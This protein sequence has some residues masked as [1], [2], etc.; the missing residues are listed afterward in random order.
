MDRFHE[1]R[2]RALENSVDRTGKWG[3]RARGR[4]EEQGRDARGQGYNT[5][6][7][8]GEVEGRLERRESMIYR[9]ARERGR[10]T[11][12]ERAARGQ[13][14]RAGREVLEGRTGKMENIVCGSSVEVDLDDMFNEISK[15]MKEKMETM[16]GNANNGE[17]VAMRAG[18]KVMVETVEDMLSRLSERV[19]AVENSVFGISDIVKQARRER[20]NMDD[21]TEVR[22]AKLEENV[23]DLEAEVRMAKLEDK[24]QD[25]EAEMD[26]IKQESSKREGMDEMTDVRLAKFEDKV[27]TLE[28]KV[29][30][31][32]ELKGE[33]KVTEEVKAMEAKV[34]EAMRAVKVVN[35][36]I[37]QDT[38]DKA[39]IVRKA[40]EEIRRHTRKEEIGFLNGILRRTRVIVLGRRTEG[41][42][43]RGRTG[44][45]VPILF[46]CQ[47]RKEGQELE[48][49]LKTAGYFT[50]FHWP[51]EVM[52]FIRKIKEEARKIG[53]TNPES[54]FRIRP[55]EREGSIRIKVDAKPKVG[56]RYTMKGIWVCPPL[57]HVLWSNVEGLYTPQVVGKG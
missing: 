25:L 23:L 16:V 7:G 38:E 21:R 18:M 19:K 8:R 3:A 47:E 42:Q 53:N 54:Y 14:N 46:Q 1:E 55:E 13:D 9:D 39:T 28:A 52:E 34:K 37:R 11:D 31:V 43:E 33:S 26:R 40:L 2:M 50:T 35:I 15:A 5:G 12:R 29:D 48:R 30:R 17:Q 56:G 6:R 24:F 20:R 49:I 27:K 10:S 44:Y 32:T 45:T 57:N 41:M 36:N 51:R 22:L 4:G